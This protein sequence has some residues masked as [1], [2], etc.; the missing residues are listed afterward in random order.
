[1]FGFWPILTREAINLNLHASAAASVAASAA[2]SA[3]SKAAYNRGMVIDIKYGC[4]NRTS[5]I[6]YLPRDRDEKNPKICEL[7]PPR[8]IC[9]YI[10][11]LLPKTLVHSKYVQ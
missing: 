8:G 5:W 1:M 2:S 10:Y 4:I 9:I 6:I 11:I 7:P 3:A